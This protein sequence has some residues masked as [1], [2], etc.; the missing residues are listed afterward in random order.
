MVTTYGIEVKVDDGYDPTT[1]VPRSKWAR[2]H[3]IGGA[4]YVWTTKAEASNNMRMCYPECG[5]ETVR[6]CEVHP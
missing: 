6:V 3:P 2:V 4:P 5:P 1:G